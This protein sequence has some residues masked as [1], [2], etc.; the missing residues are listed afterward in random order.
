M[1]KITILESR[2]KK[3]IEAIDPEQ[4][5]RN[6]PGYVGADFAK[7]AD[8]GDLVRMVE[9]RDQYAKIYNK[10]LPI[11]KQINDLRKQYKLSPLK[12]V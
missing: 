4:V 11:Q 12:T 7:V 1:K 2:I 10:L 5:R 3:I 8:D 9:L 6:T